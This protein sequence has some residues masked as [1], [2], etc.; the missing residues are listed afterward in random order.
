MRRALQ[1]SHDRHDR[2]IPARE[3]GVKVL[4]LAFVVAVI[5]TVVVTYVLIT[6]FERKQEA[7]TPFV[8]VAE[9]DEVTTDPEPWGEN[10]PVQFEGWKSTSG[11]KFYGGSSALPES[12]L[13]QDPWLKRLYAGYAFSI[14]YREARGH[15]YMLYDQ[16]VTERITKK[17]QAGA[18][19]HCHAS[20]SV[21][22]RKAG[23]EAMGEPADVEALASDF[24]REAVIRGFEEVSR[25]PYGEV[26]SMLRAAPDGTPETNESVFHKLRTAVTPGNWR[27]NPSRAG[28]KRMVWRTRS[29]ASIAT[30]RR[31]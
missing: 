2:S 24:N 4:F 12:K 6:M 28:P 22:Y 31:R 1:T 16:G 27:A 10:W 3:G 8:R 17:P 20:T 29:P 11:D 15:A 18:C 7:R 26:L 21:M 19:L 25:K 13:E 14:D 5:A 23:L 9:V 30:T